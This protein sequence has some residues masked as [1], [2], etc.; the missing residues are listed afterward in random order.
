MLELL[1]K[2]KVA[3]Y[4]LLIIWNQKASNETGTSLAQKAEKDERKKWAGDR[5]KD[6]KWESLFIDF[7]EGEALNLGAGEGARKEDA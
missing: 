3:G 7:V 6:K 5:L 2:Q 1:R 4:D